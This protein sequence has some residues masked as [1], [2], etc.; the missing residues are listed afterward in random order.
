MNC[1]LMK[2]KGN[3][4]YTYIKLIYLALNK[5]IVQNRCDICLYRGDI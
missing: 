2:L 3:D 1:K 5:K 4:F